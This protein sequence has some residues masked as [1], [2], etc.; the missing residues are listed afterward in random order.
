MGS[1]NLFHKRKAQ[2]V[3]SLIREKREKPQKSKYLIVCE[4]SVTEPNYFKGLRNLERLPTAHVAIFGEECNSDPLSV[5]EYAYQQYE[6]ERF[7]RFDEVFCVIDRD[8]HSNFKP[9]VSRVDGLRKSGVPIGLIVSW[10]CFEYWVLLH[11]RYS[12]NPYH[13]T[14]RASG[15]DAVIS[16][17][18]HNHDRRYEKAL[19]DIY[20]A[21]K[22]MQATALKHAALAQA[23]AEATGEENPSTQVH[24]LVEKL[25]ALNIG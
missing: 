4:G 13:P 14:R 17:I 5:V 2:R 21:L 24:W 10:P 15:C 3:A 25:L 12:R 18:R 6:A 16:D 8:G 19:V 7:D 11:H 20:A 22:P 9:A 1:D 23:D